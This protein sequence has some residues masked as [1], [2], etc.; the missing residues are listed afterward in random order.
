MRL[1]TITHY[2]WKINGI[3][4]TLIKR[5]NKLF[6]KDDTG[7]CEI[8][9]A[10]NNKNDIDKIINHINYRIFKIYKHKSSSGKIGDYSGTEEIKNYKHNWPYDRSY[11]SAGNKL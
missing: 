11:S 8:K 1:E 2:V 5:E 6:I 10:H 7:T 3:E 9:P 4:I